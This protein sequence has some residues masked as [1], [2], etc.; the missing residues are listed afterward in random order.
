MP[1]LLSAGTTSKVLTAT[2]TTWWTARVRRRS[3]A[4][5]RRRPPR[6]A[7]A[8]SASSRRAASFATSASLCFTTSAPSTVITNALPLSSS[9]LPLP[10]ARANRGSEGRPPVCSAL[11]RA[12]RGIKAGAVLGHF[13]PGPLFSFLGLPPSP[14]FDTADCGGR[15]LLG[16]ASDFHPPSESPFPRPPLEA[17]ERPLSRPVPRITNMH[18]HFPFFLCSGST[19]ASL[20]AFEWKVDIVGR[21]PYDL[22]VIAG[23]GEEAA[24][25]G[26]C[27]ARVSPVRLDGI[28]VVSTRT[29]QRSWHDA[30][31]GAYLFD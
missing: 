21:S 8:G 17:L 14:P 3:P 28:I 25:R 19:L 31:A 22:C 2:R 23:P 15:L 9:L 13:S 5:R 16:A 11:I 18:A 10:L 24:N 6:R 27:C 29:S 30:H 7:A 4:R 12:R 20:F 1:F 26:T